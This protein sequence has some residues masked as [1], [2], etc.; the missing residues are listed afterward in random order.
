MRLDFKENCVI[1]SDIPTPPSAN[2]YVNRRYPT[3]KKK[4]FMESWN[5]GVMEIGNKKKIEM[6][7]FLFGNINKRSLFVERKALATIR[8][9][10]Y[11]STR[12][13]TKKG[14]KM[15]LFDSSNRIKLLEDCLA[16]FMGVDDCYF[17]DFS[18][19]TINHET[20]DFF[21]R[22]YRPCYFR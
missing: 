7:K 1:I 5:D 19:T 15:K 4:I 17:K 11:W 21:V 8:I 2:D 12:L 22:I 16:K 3:K 10:Y 14:D 9:E 13:K 20:E 6:W 18:W